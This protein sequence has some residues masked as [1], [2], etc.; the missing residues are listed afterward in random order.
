M[1]IALIGYGK[2]GKAIE[3]IA[4]E[5]GHVITVQVDVSNKHDL[6]SQGF[7]NSDVAIEFTRPESALEN[8]LHCCR[9]KVPVVVGTTGWL[10]HI[11]NVKTECKLNDSAVFY[12]SNYSIGMNI[13]F[14]LNEKLAEWMNE[15]S[16]YEVNIDETHHIHKL[17]Q[18]SGT[19]IS[20]AEGVLNSL[21][22][23]THWVNETSNDPLA[24]Y[25]RS[26]REDEIPGTHYVEYKSAID[27]LVIK[28]EAFNRTGFA[29]G[30]VKVAEWLQEKKG[31]LNMND[32]L[33]I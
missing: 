23:K 3:K 18:P 5:R 33:N 6:Q 16:D 29:L 30:A 25:I 26:N 12:A 32:F 24:L 8:I 28:H 21:D 1:N 11:D 10:D 22:R 14:A 7:L 17:D 20:L 2:M 27:S 15:L 4:K 9:S 31:I 19:A 13:T